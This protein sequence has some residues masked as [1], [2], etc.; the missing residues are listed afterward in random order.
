MC[1]KVII[2]IIIFVTLGTS[3]PWALEING[4]NLTP[5]ASWLI[6]IRARDNNLLL[7]L[8]LLLIIMHRCV[9][10]VTAVECLSERLYISTLDGMLYCGE[11]KEDRS[12]WICKSATSCGQ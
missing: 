12:G 5:G 3:F 2:I 6:I 10:L 9:Y 11:V 8:L 4:K 7:L 1:I